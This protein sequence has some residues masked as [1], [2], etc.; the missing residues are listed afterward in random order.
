MKQSR[1]ISGLPYKAINKL[2]NLN[3]E[4]DVVHLSGSV[5][6]HVKRK[7]PEYKYAIGK[8]DEVIKSPDFIGQSPDHIINFEVIKKFKKNYVLVA[9]SSRKDR[10]GDYPVM[11]AYVIYENT[12][13]KRLRTSQ[14]VE[15]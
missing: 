6:V 11:S 7:H 10:R 12:I 8:I 5:I 4:H 13:Q 9:I 2:L 15:V 3:L 14:I 1:N